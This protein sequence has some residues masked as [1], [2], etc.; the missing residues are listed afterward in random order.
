MKNTGF[1][2]LVTLLVIFA[3]GSNTFAQDSPQWHLP[4]GA[5]ARVDKGTIISEIAYS[6]D[7]KY[8]AVAS[9]TEIWLYNA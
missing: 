6:P 2:I 3:F 9:G 4:E 7:G 5:K 8:L 1:S